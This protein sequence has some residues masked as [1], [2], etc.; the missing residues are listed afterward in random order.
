MD[1]EVGSGRG[2]GEELGLQGGEVGGCDVAD[3]DGMCA[4][5]GEGV[6][7]CSADAEG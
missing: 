2:E 1:F 6:S 5:E 4:G 7:G 3:V